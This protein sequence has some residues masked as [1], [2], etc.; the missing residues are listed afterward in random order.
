MI[1]VLERSN[2]IWQNRRPFHVLNVTKIR[3]YGLMKKRQPV[4]IAEKPYP[5]H[6]PL[7]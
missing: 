4:K 3:K 7:I 1:F 5:A 2:E 6:N